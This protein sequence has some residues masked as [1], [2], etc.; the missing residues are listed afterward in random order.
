MSPQLTLQSPLELPPD[1]IPK[2]LD[3]LWSKDHLENN[4]ANTFCLLI[5]QPAWLEQH[6]VRTGLIPGPIIGTNRQ[7][8]IEASRKVILE[9]ELPHST[10]A[11]DIKVNAE[12]ESLEDINKPED[13]RGQHIDSAISALEPRRLI[14]LA[15]TLQKSEGL[16]SLV[17]A[18]CPLP[19]ETNTKT[20]CGDVVVLR[21]HQTSL[22]KG[23]GI[24]QPLLP[25]DLPSWV[26]WNGSLDESPDLLKDLALPHRR[27]IIDTALGNPLNCMRFLKQRIEEGQAINDLNWLRLRTWRETL[28]MVFDP[29]DKRNALNNIV[30]IDIDIEGDNYVQGVL[31][32]AWMADR[33]NWQLKNC[34]RE[35]GIEIISAEF[36]RPDGN[37][38]TIKIIP[39]PI[40]KPSIHPGQV[41]GI[42]MICNPNLNPS[43][44]MCVILASQSGECMRLESGGMANMELLEEVVPIPI[45]AVEADVARL[46]RTSRGSTSPLLSSAAP[47]GAEL[48]N[49]ALANK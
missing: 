33:L 41:V 49:L 1:E 37:P 15:P 48:I 14:T 16:K 36:T 25:D 8:L 10:A 31:F 28:A 3:Q 43:K 27:I 18:Y 44:K 21:G 12:L 32:A 24:L 5:W 9:R 40:G 42:R 35:V 30:Q 38:V 4:G 26:W 7:D 6:L 45:T 11:L 20:A 23:L 13:L 34:Q 17:A 47:I 22:K 2:Y 46:L 29:P 39:L 19:E